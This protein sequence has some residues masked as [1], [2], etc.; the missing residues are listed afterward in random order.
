[1]HFEIFIMFPMVIPCVFGL[2]ITFLVH[3]VPNG[4]SSPHQIT[5]KCLEFCSCLPQHVEHTIG[6]ILYV[7]Y[8][9]IYIYIYVKNHMGSWLNT[10]NISKLWSFKTKFLYNRV[11][12]KVVS[13]FVP[14]FTPYTLFQWYQQSK[15]I[16]LNLCTKKIAKTQHLMHKVRD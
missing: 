1:M 13:F 11:V 6:L 5:N 10:S 15:D 4:C 7:T 2:L 8:I 3:C 12:C 9:Y 14:P 16:L